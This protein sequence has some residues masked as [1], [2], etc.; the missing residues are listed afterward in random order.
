VFDVHEPFSGQLYARVASG[1]DAARSVVQGA[2]GAFPD[3]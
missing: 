1:R 3:C 2:A